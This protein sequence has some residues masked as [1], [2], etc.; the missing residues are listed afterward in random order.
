MNNIDLINRTIKE[1]FEQN[2][3]VNIIRA[4]DLM[5]EFIKAGVFLNDYRSG[6]PI[7]KV[8][9]E[10]DRVNQLNLIPCVVA[11]RKGVN[12]NWYFSRSIIDFSENRKSKNEKETTFSNN[13][14]EIYILDLCDE[15]LGRKGSRQH[16]FDFLRGDAGTKLPVD[17]YYEDL[18]LVV[19]Y[20]EYQH[21]NEVVFFD[22]P[23]IMT[24]SGVSRKEQREIYDQRR[25]DVLS[26][27]N[28][29]LVE[30]SYSEFNVRSNH[31]IDRNKEHDLTVL[32]KR[33]VMENVKL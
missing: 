6:L 18:A 1:Y 17:T 11:D 31:R 24:V 14:D 27:Q 28:I 13:R 10:L 3:S 20:C 25:R 19:E 22:K 4:K 15:I 21:T 26:K 12:V 16:R 7:R 8:L 29:K 33:L 30:I 32:K 9:R 23:D 5:L 2:K